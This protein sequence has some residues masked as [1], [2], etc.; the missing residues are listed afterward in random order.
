AFG[1]RAESYAAK[2]RVIH[3]GVVLQNAVARLQAM[4]GNL[5]QNGAARE[6]HFAVIDPEGVVVLVAIRNRLYDRVGDRQCSDSPAAAGEDR[7]GDRSL[8]LERADRPVNPKSARHDLGPV[9][10]VSVW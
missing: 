3:F 2:L 4:N 6:G 10:G 7:P 1:K 9:Y 8:D 5:A